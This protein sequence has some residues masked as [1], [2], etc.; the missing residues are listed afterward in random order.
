MEAN[1]FIP[2][3][4][5]RTRR[6]IHGTLRRLPRH[7]GCGTTGW[8][9][10]ESELVTD[11]NFKG[12]Y[13]YNFA[14]LTTSVASLRCQSLKCSAAQTIVSPWNTSR[15]EN[16][17]VRGG[18]REWRFQT[19]SALRFRPVAP[20]PESLAKCEPGSRRLATMGEKVG[21]VETR[22]SQRRLDFCTD[23]TRLWWCFQLLL[24]NH[25]L[26]QPPFK[27]P[28]EAKRDI[29]VITNI[30]SVLVNILEVTRVT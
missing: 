28:Q 14:G 4:S 12:N 21:G 7:D 5:A 13:F 2:E 9:N 8:G 10:A 24:G 16:T 19:L 27:S 17:S 1:A 11:K 15:E 26:L 20:S 6:Q 25:P 30:T 29:S 18:G 23:G 3:S 22:E